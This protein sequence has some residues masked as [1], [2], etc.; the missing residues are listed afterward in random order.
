MST[1]QPG[2]T[3]GGVAPPPPAATPAAPPP[4]AAATPAA[5]DAT[6]V[7]RTSDL[8]SEALS[9]RLQREAQKAAREAREAVLRE[10]GID[11]PA[12]YK[13][14]SAKEREELEQ[15][16]KQEE[17]RQRAAMTEQQRLQA[18]LEKLR[19]EREE[20]ETKLKEA[21]EN[22]ITEQQ[23]AVVAR[24]ASKYIDPDMYEYARHDFVKHVQKLLA[25]DPKQVAEMTDKDVE[26]FFR[27]LAQRKPKFALAAGATPTIA[28][29][30]VAITTGPSPKTA[31]GSPKTPI[32]PG[33]GKTA[34]P[35]QANSMNDKE[36][37]ELANSLGVRWPP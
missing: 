13:A 4:P 1:Q 17:E 34:R 9:E 28:A 21:E 18:D 15:L 23:E 12:A 6:K 8:S 37:K 31:T 14:R 29:R 20:L 35:N 30:K 33:G 27:V 19:K 11:D 36:V 2:E 24:T 16:K 22:R 7:P 3:Q 26:R 32:G 10:L 5:H 25:E